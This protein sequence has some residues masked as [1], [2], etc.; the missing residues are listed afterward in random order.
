VRPQR[1]S[2]KLTAIFFIALATIF[3]QGI[4]NFLTPD[5]ARVGS[6]L[7]CRCGGCKNTVGDC[8]MLRCDY[9]DPLRRRIFAMQA[10]GMS[11]SAIIGTIVQERG[12]AAL[13]GQQPLGILVWLTPAI[14]LAIGFLIYSRYV[15]RNRRAPEPLTAG[16][17]AMIDRFRA[18]IDRETDDSPASPLD[19]KGGSERK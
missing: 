15:R 5:V 7:A 19:G 14:A 9:T 4:T 16:D 10:R 11:D 12:E 13:A 2:L 17:Q 8:P 6:K 3:A 1:F 18:Q